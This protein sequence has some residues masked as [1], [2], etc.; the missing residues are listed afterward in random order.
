MQHKHRLLGASLEAVGDSA[1]IKSKEI[2]QRYVDR[3]RHQARVK[4]KASAAAAA[5]PFK[6]HGPYVSYYAIF[7]QPSPL[8]LPILRPMLCRL[9]RPQP[10]HPASPLE[11]SRP[12]Q[13]QQPS[14]HWW[15]FQ[16]A[17]L[18]RLHSMW[19]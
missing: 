7:P 14:S 2:V 18:G 5:Q 4:R 9:P 13:L 10:P 17:L 15:A 16:L 8:A 3:G 19:P 12:A 11:S 1:L 6:L